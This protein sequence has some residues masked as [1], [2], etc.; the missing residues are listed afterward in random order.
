MRDFY[1]QR[2]SQDYRISSKPYLLFV[3]LIVFEHIEHC[4]A[5][6]GAG[7]SLK[8]RHTSAVFT[9][10]PPKRVRF[11][12][13]SSMCP[14]CSGSEPHGVEIVVSVS[15][16]PV[17]GSDLIGFGVDVC[18]P[19]EVSAN[20]EKGK[21][22]VDVDGNDSRDAIFGVESCSLACLAAAIRKGKCDSAAPFGTPA[23]ADAAAISWNISMTDCAVA[24]GTVAVAMMVDGNE[25]GRGATSGK[26]RYGLKDCGDEAAFFVP[27]SSSFC[28]SVV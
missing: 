1:E 25:I 21:D 18:G 9:D 7:N 2:G 5:C 16:T 12:G 27:P 23:L 20:G 4:A 11:L 19:S 14:R 13:F 28:C 26:K 17:P 10:E 15:L 6:S 24:V 3:A 22:G 8:K